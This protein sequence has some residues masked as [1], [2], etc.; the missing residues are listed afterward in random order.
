VTHVDP[1]VHPP[2]TGQETEPPPPHK[3]RDP[4]HP[5]WP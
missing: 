4:G 5:E 3:D 2:I 1:D